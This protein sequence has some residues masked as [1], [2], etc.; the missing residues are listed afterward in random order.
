MV[1]KAQSPLKNN[2][3]LFYPL[4][5]YDQIIMPDGT[6]WNGIASSGGNSGNV[7]DTINYNQIIMPD[8]S[9]WDGKTIG[10][11]LTNINSG[12][13]SNINAN[14]LNGKTA[15]YYAKAE[16]AL[17]EYGTAGQFLVKNSDANYDVAWK[18][19]IF[20]QTL[21]MELLW[22]NADPTASMAAQTI[23]FDYNNNDM[24]LIEYAYNNG[25]ESYLMC[26]QILNVIIGDA[27]RL[28]TV[29][30]TSSSAYPQTRDCV[31]LENGL[32]IKGANRGGSSN[33]T[34][35]IPRRIYGIK[36]VK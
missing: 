11:D 25:T 1:F 35:C 10:V 20:P 13:A 28:Q 24:I 33:N 9:F 17:P 29:A 34:V 21:K 12:E 15:D 26:S 7:G 36:G 14:L 31:I 16:A 6:R 2:N 23:S 18:N 8:G 30:G 32:E 19:V 3:T 4:T 27:V 5:T 22:E